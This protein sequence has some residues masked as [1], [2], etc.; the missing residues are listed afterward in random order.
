MLRIRQG[1]ATFS[2]HTEMLVENLVH[3]QLFLDPYRN[4]RYETGK[5]SRS[6]GMVGFQQSFELEE[7]L[8]VKRDCRE[9]AVFEA[10]FFENIT[11]GMNRKGRVVLSA[12]KPLFLSG[13]DN[14]AINQDC[15]STIVIVR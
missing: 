5:A 11:A 12:C 7:R 10:R 9:F 15:R 2:E 8:F 6:K 1:R 13:G 14:F 4:R 3:E